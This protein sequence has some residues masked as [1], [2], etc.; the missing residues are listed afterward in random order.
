M[1]C[2]FC[3]N[4]DSNVKDSRQAE[5]GNAIRRRRQCPECKARFT[6]YERVQ[7]RE[8][9]V[10]KNSGKLERYDRDKLAHSMQ[11]CLQ[12][13]PISLEQID[14]IVS[15]ITRQLEASGETEIP[16]GKIGEFVMES[17]VDLDQVGYVRYAS[18]YKD[19]QET[20]DFN[21]FLEDLKKLPAVNEK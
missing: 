21:E 4:S 16:S 20:S 8:L 7:L 17:L 11:L 6:T 2:P 18:V 12:K 3:N 13:R 1:H 5:D 14:K 9:T 10:V 15:S 19:F